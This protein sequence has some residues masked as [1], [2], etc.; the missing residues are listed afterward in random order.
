ME[1]VCKIMTVKHLNEFI[2]KNYYKIISFIKKDS[3]CLL[4]KIKKGLVLFDANL[5]KKLY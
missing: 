5:T 2:F 1:N 4:K 3:Y